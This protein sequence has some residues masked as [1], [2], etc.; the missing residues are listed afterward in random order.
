[1][2][3]VIYIYVALS[4]A[5]ATQP[6]LEL[7]S[8]FPSVRNKSWA[9]IEKNSLQFV[10]G[11]LFRLWWS[12]G[13]GGRKAKLPRC[14]WNTDETE[15]GIGIGF[16][17]GCLAS[18]LRDKQKLCC[19][20]TLSGHRCH[21]WN[22]PTDSQTNTDTG[23]EEEAGA[24]RQAHTHNGAIGEC[25]KK[26]LEECWKLKLCPRHGNKDNLPRCGHEWTATSRLYSGTNRG[27]SEQK[28]LFI[29]SILLKGVLLVIYTKIYLWY[30][31]LPFSSISY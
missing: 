7:L 3:L 8:K 21:S 2:V 5:S 26:T 19:H 4:A 11:H 23:A 27:L 31:V 18:T 28:Y 22:K 16:G 13:G 9:D 30:R 6:G 14:N 24:G 25:N 1:M 17:I 12:A 10:V 29:D 15:T 20:W